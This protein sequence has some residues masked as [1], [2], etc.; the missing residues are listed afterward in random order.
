MSVEPGIGAAFQSQLQ[1]N[2][3][4]IDLPSGSSWTWSTDDPSDTLTQGGG[5]GSTVKVV[6]AAGNSGRTSVTVT[7]STTDPAG[8]AVS[9]S[10]T[11]DIIPGVEHTYS[12]SVAQ[13][14][15]SP[16]K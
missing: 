1:D 11:T 14:F 4:A 10:V 13:I 9:G 2:G 12:V 7:A 5:D 6:V 8:Q 16:R 3:N 15:A